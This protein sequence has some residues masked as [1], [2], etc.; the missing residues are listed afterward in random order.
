MHSVLQGFPPDNNL[1]FRGRG[2]AFCDA[3]S[4]S[5]QN[6]IEIESCSVRHAFL[7]RRASWLCCTH[8]EVLI[9][10]L[11]ITALHPLPNS[12]SDW[13]WN[14][15]L[16]RGW[17]RKVLTL[18]TSIMFPPSVSIVLFPLG[19]MFK[20]MPERRIY[21]DTNSEHSGSCLGLFIC[22]CLLLKRQVL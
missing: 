17:Y 6:S 11:W 7:N 9:F 8:Y 14:G 1:G 5:Q 12:K 22:L 15:R 18:K 19:G 3:V 2:A 21:L 20:A 10:C 13:V 4:E 16:A